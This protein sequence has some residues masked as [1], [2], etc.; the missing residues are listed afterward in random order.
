M[1]KR[2]RG[3]PRKTGYTLIDYR[4]A[5][6]LTYVAYYLDSGDVKSASHACRKM[7]VRGIDEHWE[8]Y[9]L[10][11]SIKRPLA[12]FLEDELK[13]AKR[14]ASARKLANRALLV[15]RSKAPNAS[16]ADAAE[17]LINDFDNLATKLV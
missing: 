7:A 15:V 1:A 13:N 4:R 10:G 9:A 3:R 5:I 11:K 8:R 14:S 17:L 12:V 16:R 6:L 2:K